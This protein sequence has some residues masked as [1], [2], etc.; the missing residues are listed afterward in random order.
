[1]AQ[2]APAART[3][4][5]SLSALLRQGWER[6]ARKSN[7][8]IERGMYGEDILLTDSL[9]RELNARELHPDSY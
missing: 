3:A 9:E 4:S 8:A 5:F 7:R 2:V 1:M 6:F